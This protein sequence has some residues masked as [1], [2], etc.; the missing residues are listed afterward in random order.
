MAGVATGVPGCSDRSGVGVAARWYGERDEDGEARRCGGG[1]CG[2]AGSDADSEV[3]SGCSAGSG[4]MVVRQE[5]RCASKSGMVRRKELTVCERRVRTRKSGDVE[6]EGMIGCRR[7]RAM[8]KSL[9][10]FSAAVVVFA[11][12]EAGGC[13]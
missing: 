11:G 8:A 5:S 1:V 6:L 4:S 12:D 7:E 13:G 10:A 3:G 2:G 9:C